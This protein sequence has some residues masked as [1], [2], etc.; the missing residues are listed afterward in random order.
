MK[1]RV[2]MYTT[3]YCGYCERARRLLR[4][5]Q[6]PFD[7][8]DVTSDPAR[9]QRVIEET[10]HRTVPVILIDGRLVGGSD[11]LADLD[12][13]GGLDELGGSAGNV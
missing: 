10:G 1:P 7:E 8:V 2:L 11:D 9:R 13:A 6:I 4:S 5:R 12:R 3:A